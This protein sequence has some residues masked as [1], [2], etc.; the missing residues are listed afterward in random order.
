MNLRMYILHSIIHRH[1]RSNQTPRRI[2]IHVYRPL[3]CFRL[4]E[5]E[6]GRYQGGHGIS[7]F[8]VNADDSFAEEARVD[9]EGSFASGSGFEDYRD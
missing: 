6:L 9:V 3:W 7:N 1:T 2:D 8:A 5:E 4:E